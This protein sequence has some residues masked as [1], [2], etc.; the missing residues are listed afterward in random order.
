MKKAI[1][2]LGAIGLTAFVLV[3]LN[4]GNRLFP[5]LVSAQYPAMEEVVRPIPTAR[6]TVYRPEQV[7]SFPGKVKAA[8]RAELSFQIAG[9]I[10]QLNILEGQQVEKGDLLAALDRKNYLYEVRAAKATYQALKQDFSRA[11]Q[12][13]EEKVISQA[14]YD[15]ARSAH[16]VARARLDVKRKALADTRLVAPFNG[17]VAKRYVEKKEHVNKGESVLL[18]QNVT[19]IE[20]EVQLPEQLAARGGVD[21]LDQLSVRFNADP[22]LS[23]P[24]EAMEL[25]LESSR[26][27]R[28][29]ALVIKLTSPANMQLLPG[30][31]AT[32]T[33][34]VK[35]PA[36]GTIQHSSVLIPV[37]AVAFDPNA[38][39]Y[40]WVVDPKAQ[41]AVKRPVRTGPMHGDSIEVTKGISAG[42]LVATAGLRSLNE[43]RQVRPMKTGKKGLEG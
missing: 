13:Y 5:K 8:R 14:R 20:V 29:F 27:T 30:M 24:A 9:Q 25:S 16:D 36:Q 41:K 21:I 7:F 19:G 2:C 33:G 26:D 4:S 10:E 15:A 43:G 31:T 28:T 1:I 12:L 6:A 39:P 42:E 3:F 40:V 32:V 23:F 18:L 38:S 17:L 34:A 35:Q 22:S 37:E 11:S